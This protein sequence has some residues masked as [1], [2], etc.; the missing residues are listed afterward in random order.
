M[1][2][3]RIDLKSANRSK[4]TEHVLDVAGQVSVV[5]RDHAGI[6]MPQKVGDMGNADSAY[7]LT[8]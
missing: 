1:T 2:T 6:D 4:E 7:P 8:G 5:L 3:D